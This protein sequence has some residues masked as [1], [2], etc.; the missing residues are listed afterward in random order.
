VSAPQ[1]PPGI[2]GESESKRGSSVN[3][4]TSIKRELCTMCKDLPVSALVDCGEM[5]SFCK[6][7]AVKWFFRDS[8]CPLCQ[9]E[10][11]ELKVGE[12]FIPVKYARQPTQDITEHDHPIGDTPTAATSRRRRRPEPVVEQDDEP[13]VP[14]P[15]RRPRPSENVV[16]EI[17]DVPMPP[18]PEAPSAPE[19]PEPSVPPNQDAID[20]HNSMQ[21]Y[22][23]IARDALATVAGL[24]R[25]REPDRFGEVRADMPATM[26]V[27]S[28]TASTMVVTS[29]IVKKYTSLDTQL[30]RL[31]RWHTD[32]AKRNYVTRVGEPHFRAQQLV[33]DEIERK[34][35]RAREAEAAVRR[36]REEIAR[37]QSSLRTSRQR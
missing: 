30:E 21:S 37:L 17:F 16:G 33:R 7:C 15:R 23:M 5:H 35:V 10:V 22:I 14:S 8:R 1:S 18:P 6:T 34:Q 26:D 27:N 3:A 4:T 12:R 9:G 19:E 36:E 28:Y 32:V 20:L 24:L 13:Y 2:V 25:A 11:T 29:K 31:G